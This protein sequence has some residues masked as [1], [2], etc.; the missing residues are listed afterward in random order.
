[1]ENT[2]KLTKQ[3]VRDLSVVARVTRV[4]NSR[5]VAIPPIVPPQ[6][7]APRFKLFVSHDCGI[8]YEL[9]KEGTEQELAPLMKRYNMEVLRWFTEEVDEPSSIT[10]S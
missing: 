3:G 6:E 4:L 7:M 1:M 5:K 9:A 2:F 10:H 8:H